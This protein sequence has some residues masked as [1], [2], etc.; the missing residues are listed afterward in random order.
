[1]SH[2]L[3]H[4]TKGVN[5]RMT[6]CPRCGGPGEE[7]ILLGRLDMKFTCARCHQ[8][9]YGARHCLNEKCQSSHG[10]QEPIEEHERLPGGLCK[11][12]EAKQAAVDAMVQAGGA[13]FRCKRCKSE[14][15]IK[16]DV[17]LVIALRE[18]YGV[19]APNPIGVE[20]EMCPH[21]HDAEDGAIEPMQ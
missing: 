1:M 4:P 5:P 17:P 14:G 12:C 20:L 15:A 3:L 2:I 18:R 10:T 6:Q 7:I 21:C 19:V 11:A 8:V 16:A 13:Y 9:S